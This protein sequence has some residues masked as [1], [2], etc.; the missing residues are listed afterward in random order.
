[1]VRSTKACSQIDPW[2]CRSDRLSVSEEDKK[3]LWLIVAVPESHY[4]RLEWSIIN[5][6]NDEVEPKKAP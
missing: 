6:A 1:M 3:G 2:L 5:E 4:S